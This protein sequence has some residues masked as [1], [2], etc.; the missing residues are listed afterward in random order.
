MLESQS[1][2]RIFRSSL[3]GIKKP[4]PFRECFT[5]SLLYPK[6][7]TDT[8]G[9]GISERAFESSI[10]KSFNI[11]ADACAGDARTTISAS[12]VSFDE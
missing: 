2:P 1:V 7:T 9:Y 12:T 6:Q 5:F 8:W 3:C 11:S 4:K 10:S